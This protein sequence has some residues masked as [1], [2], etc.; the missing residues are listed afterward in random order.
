M[1]TTEAPPVATRMRRACA[2]DEALLYE[3]FAADKRVEFGVLG[4]QGAQA[5]MLIEVQYRG[6]K[7]TYAAQ[8][9]KAEN[10][11]LLGEGGSAAGRLLVDRGAECWRILDIAI[12][13]GQRGR[14]LATAALKDCQEQ[15]AK[16][17]ASLKLQTTPMNPARRLYERL[18]FRTTREDA[19]A[20]EMAWSAADFASR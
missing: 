12:L 13:V 3:L 18:G 6:R 9:P 17:G 14:G 2:E 20:V 16:S 19:M 10:W 7:I 11:I 5:E 1:V 15:C 8:Y 4:L